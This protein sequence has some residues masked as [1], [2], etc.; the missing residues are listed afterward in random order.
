VAGRVRLET[1]G[2]PRPVFYAALAAPSIP[3]AAV[4]LYL[5]YLYPRVPLIAIP[6]VLVAGYAIAILGARRWPDGNAH[7]RAVLIPSGA[8]NAYMYIA[9]FWEIAGPGG[10]AAAAGFAALIL[11]PLALAGEPQPGDMVMRPVER[12]PDDWRW[13]TPS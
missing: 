8:A 2:L 5:I 13:T 3:V 6:V 12:D 7:Y 4:G 11:A 10:G 1:Y 9:V